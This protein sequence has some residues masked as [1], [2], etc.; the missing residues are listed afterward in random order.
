M[1]LHIAIRDIREEDAPFICGTW[2]QGVFYGSAHSLS[3]P[4][5]EWFKRFSDY[6]EHSIKTGEVFV[7]CLTDD[8]DLILGYAVFK[9]PTLEWVF[10]KHIYRLH[11]IARLLLKDKVKAIN[12]LTITKLGERLLPRLNLGETHERTT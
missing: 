9:G 10:V 2:S 6:M 12:P 1:S 7:A 11:G 4:K 8:P 3:V 5:E